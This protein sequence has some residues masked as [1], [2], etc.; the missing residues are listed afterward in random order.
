VSAEEI[1][2]KARDRRNSGLITYYRLP[3]DERTRGENYTILVAAERLKFLLV[4]HDTLLQPCE[5]M[6]NT[7]RRRRRDETVEL[8][9]IGSVNTE[10][11]RRQ[12]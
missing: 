11:T 9:R 4:M 7:H 3:A 12:S 6:P 10:H 8:R 2:T 1:D 5:V